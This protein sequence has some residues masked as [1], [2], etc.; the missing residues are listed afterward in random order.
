[1]VGGVT[2][3]VGQ[4]VCS[5][6]ISVELTDIV[7]SLLSVGAM[8]GFLRV[9]QPGRAAARRGRRRRPARD[10]G[11][12]RRT[13][14]PTR[15]PCAAGRARAR[16]PARDIFERLRA[17]RDHHRRLRPRPAR[18]DQGLP[19][20]GRGRVHVAG[21]G[22]SSHA[23]GEA[24][25]AVTYKFN[26]LAAA[27]TL[28]LVC[29]LHDDGRAARSPPPA[30]CAPTARMLN[31]L[32][33]AT[34]TVAAVLALAYVMNLSAQTLSDRQLDRRRRRRA[35]VPLADHR[36]A[37]HGGDGLGHLLELAVR[38]APGDRGQG[39]RAGP[40]AARRRQLLRR[41]AGQDDLAAEPRDR[42]RRRRVGRSGG[43]PVPHV[44]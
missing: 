39:G 13:T 32:K 1:M 14:R 44:S 36:L 29:G 41:R 43:R 9:W 35:R 30:P 3:A 40:D 7:A 18:A 2:F 6:Y 37:R 16:T 10:R 28:L 27:G 34:L 38:R 5:N 15:R 24:P 33:W 31:Q 21:P 19:G 26:W 42:R 8:V 17:V 22:R 25:T 11:R 23:K 4:F 12:G 20:Q